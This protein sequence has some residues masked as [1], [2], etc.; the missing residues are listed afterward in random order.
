MRGKLD[1]TRRYHYAVVLSHQFNEGQPVFQR[2][3]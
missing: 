2:G 1:G 3:G